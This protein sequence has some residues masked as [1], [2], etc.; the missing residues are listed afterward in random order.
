MTKLLKSIKIVQ[1][2]DH[3]CTATFYYE[4]RCSTDFERLFGGCSLLGSG[5]FLS[6]GEIVDGDRK[7][8]VQQRVFFND[9]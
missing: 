6:V 2:H 4:S 1:S 8:D 9:G 7:K 5:Q 3:K